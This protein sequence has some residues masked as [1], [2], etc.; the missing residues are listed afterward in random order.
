[1][2]KSKWIFPAL[3]LATATTAIISCKTRFNTTNAAY[4]AD[5]S[6]GE[7]ER[8][9]VLV[10]SSCAGCHYNTSANKFIGN[11]IDDVPGIAGQVYSAN[12]TNSKTHG[13]PAKYTDAQLKYLLKTGIAHD[14]RFIPY[15]LRPNMAE[16]DLDAIVA[17]LRSDDPAV[18]AADTTVGLT[19]YNAIGKIYMNMN[20][21]PLPYLANVKRPSEN[22]PVALGAYLA[23]NLGCFHCHSKSLTSLDYLHPAQSKGFMEGGL[24]LKGENGAT[25]TASNITPDKE[26]GIGGFTK[27]QFFRALT[28][29]EAPQRKLH[30]PMPQFKMLSVAEIDA[31]YAYIQTIPPVNHK[32]KLY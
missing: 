20:A 26:T 24:K 21:K 2:R 31:I 8:G 32:V 6:P 14:G 1:M 4:I 30:A 10:Y 11:R 12:L 17:F 7:V 9:R 18:A 27:D 22:E 23:D 25:V 3:L 16:S 13:I 15:M 19:H 28:D 5:K 29:G